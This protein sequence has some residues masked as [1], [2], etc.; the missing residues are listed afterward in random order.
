[1]KTKYLAYSFT[2]FLLYLLLQRMDNEFRYIALGFGIT[3]LLLGIFCKDKAEEGTDNLNKKES[4][5]K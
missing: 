5:I 4:V 3:I 2:A 1:M